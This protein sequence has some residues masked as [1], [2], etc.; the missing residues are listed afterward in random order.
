MNTE[1]F[2]HCDIILLRRWVQNFPACHTK[3]APNGKCCEGY[4]APSTV[5]LM[6][7]YQYVLG[8]YIET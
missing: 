3:A 4:I 2:D 5:R 8:D 6:Y 7:Q 1:V